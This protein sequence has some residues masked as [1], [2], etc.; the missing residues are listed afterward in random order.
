MPGLA[1]KP[2]PLRPVRDNAI[3]RNPRREVAIFPL[4][5]FDYHLVAMN[6]DQRKG[7]R[8]GMG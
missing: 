7:V 1:A 6:A 8:V 4:L 2:S 5:C 3:W